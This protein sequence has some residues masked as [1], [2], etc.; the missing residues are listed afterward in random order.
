MQTSMRATCVSLASLWSFSSAVGD[1]EGNNPMGTVLALVDELVAKINK[2]ADA[3]QKAYVEYYEW[4]DE[5][6]KNVNFAI[7]TATKENAMLEAKLNELSSD[8]QNAD[9]KIEELAAA[10]SKDEAELKD[11]TAIRA[12]EAADFKASEAELGES[13][14]ALSR[15]IDI[16]GKEMAKNPASFAQLNTKNIASAVQALGVVLDAASFSSND[17]KKLVAFVQ[18]QQGDDASDDEFG[19]PAAAVYKSQSGGILD[20]LE[21]MKEKAEGQLSELRKE[22]VS[23]QHNFAMLKQSLED[24]MAADSKDMDDAKAGKAAAEEATATAQGELDVTKKALGGST[25]QL[26]TTRGSCLQVAADHEAVVAAR[27]EE[28]AVLAKA[29]EILVETS[30]GAVSQTYSFAQV[31]QGVRMSTHADLVGSEVVTAVKRLAAQQKSAALA[32]LASRIATV[33]RFGAAGNA[34]PFGKVKG[35]IRDMIAK[36]EKEGNADAEEK[37]FCDEQ[38]SKTEAKKVE[39]EGDIE[40]MSTRIDQAAAKSVQLKEEIQELE[41][42]LA[43]LAKGQA[44][45][46]KIRQ[47]ER[48]AYDTAKA[49]LELGLSG[50]RKALDVLREYYG[51][52][53]MLQDETKF[54]SLMQQPSKPESFKK[55]SGAGGGIID[56]LE[57]CESD[58]AT[59]LAKIEAEEGDAQSEYEKITQDNAVTKTTKDQD[60]KYKVKESKALDTTAA[61]YS[62]DR[63]TANKELTAVLDY[64]GKIK[65]RCIAKPESYADRKARREAEIQGLKDAL[66]I[67]ENE[68]ALVQRKKRSS[69]FRGSLAAQ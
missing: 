7:E 27:K 4:C 19:A 51:G 36:L 55:S 12:K 14:S 65:D 46:D 22:E 3:E 45:L 38:M 63:E 13:L 9:S 16:L 30:K 58:F 5:T 26:A 69:S 29:K 17:Q 62:A 50:V 41:A 21:D 57:V 1:E 2:D 24:Q 52:A 66:S 25:E 56:I 23:A 44:E 39:L 60:V 15:A 8:I 11:A 59:N 20:V 67:L 43:A 49:D 34:N 10:I 54:G 33:L 61:E 68:T 53:S 37:A 32:Q 31:S 40:K 42:E 48:T 6:S 18:S 47:E 35:L 64:Y 28:L